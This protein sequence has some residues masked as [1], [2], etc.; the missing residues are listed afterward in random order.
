MKLLVFLALGLAASVSPVAVPKNHVF[1]SCAFP[2]GT[3]SAIHVYNCDG[4]WPLMVNSALVYDLS[5]NT[6]YP[7]D[8]RK[9]MTLHLDSVNN[10]V[11]YTDNKVDVKI[12][13]YTQDWIS[14]KCKWSEVPTFGLLNGIDG[15]DYAHNCP[16]QTGPLDLILPLNLTGFASI[17]NA[18]ASNRPYELQIKMKDYNQ[19]SSHEE[20]ACVV[21]QVKFSET[22]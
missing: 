21:A 13:E 15:C 14:G 11:P 7:I 12:F 8:P 1:A 20:I 22:G 2:N 18:L 10:G 17:I 5:N 9:P 16:L 6:M 19:G 4:T 3:D